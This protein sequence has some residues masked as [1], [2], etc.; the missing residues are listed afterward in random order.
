MD[1]VGI[2]PTTSS[3]QG[4]HS[5]A[6]LQ[7]LVFS[8]AAVFLKCLFFLIKSSFLKKICCKGSLAS[9]IFSF[10]YAI[11]FIIKKIFKGLS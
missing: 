10:Y 8:K 6:E 3:V 11:N 1:P 7:A 5:T 4:R 9:T 2:E